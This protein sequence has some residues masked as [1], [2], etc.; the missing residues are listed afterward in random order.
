MVMS[1]PFDLNL[2][3]QRVAIA[4]VEH[5]RRITREQFLGY[6]IANDP[7]FFVVIVKYNAMRAYS[8]GIMF[9]SGAYIKVLSAA[10]NFVNSVWFDE[11]LDP[12]FIGPFE[13]EDINLARH[14]AAKAAKAYLNLNS[15]G[16]L[17]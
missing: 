5:T 2:A 1:K 3:H 17:L 8:T 12:I 7:R 16:G 4:A 10:E 11:A 13:T 6:R 9:V 14:E 15:H